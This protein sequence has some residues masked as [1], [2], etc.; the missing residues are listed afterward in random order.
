MLYDKFKSLNLPSQLY[1]YS[2]EWH[3]WNNQLVIVD[4]YEKAIDLLTIQLIKYL[5]ELIYLFKKDSLSLIIVQTVN[6]I[7]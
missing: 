2:D 1:F 6:F 4:S 3:S 5:F 7:E